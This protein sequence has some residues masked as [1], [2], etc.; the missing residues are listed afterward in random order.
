[1]YAGGRKP[2]SAQNEKIR[3]NFDVRD[4]YPAPLP[5]P[6]SSLTF[7]K[8]LPLGK[9]GQVQPL[10]VLPLPLDPILPG[11]SDQSP[12][13]GGS[14]GG[15]NRDGTRET[16]DMDRASRE[17]SEVVETRTSDPRRRNTIF[18]DSV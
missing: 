4:P 16:E 9:V 15:S 1:M 13:Q 7:A 2:K 3:P 8:K 5:A 18:R 11:S 6:N 17:R 14:A 12:S 10:P